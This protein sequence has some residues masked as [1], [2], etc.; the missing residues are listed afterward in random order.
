MREASEGGRL[1]G[2]ESEGGSKKEVN[3]ESEELG[4]RGE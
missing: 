1:R 4:G 2:G 3:E